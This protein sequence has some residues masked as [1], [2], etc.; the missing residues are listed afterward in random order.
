MEITVYSQIDCTPGINK[1]RLNNWQNYL[2]TTTYVRI[3]LDV[4]NGLE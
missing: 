4:R 1:R 2:I 3:G